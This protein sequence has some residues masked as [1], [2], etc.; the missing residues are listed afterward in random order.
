[1]LQ[2]VAS[3]NSCKDANCL[4]AFCHPRFCRLSNTII[5]TVHM[6]AWWAA[7][8]NADFSRTSSA[9]LITFDLRDLCLAP[10]GTASFERVFFIFRAVVAIS[11]HRVVFVKPKFHC[12]LSLNAIISSEQIKFRLGNL[13]FTNISFVRRSPRFHLLHFST[14][15]NFLCSHHRIFFS[16]C[17]A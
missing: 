7:L 3:Q 6:A 2:G 1:M 4:T 13:S 14:P 17:C 11:D 8:N 12:R 15:C 10:S 9:P 5:S 16:F